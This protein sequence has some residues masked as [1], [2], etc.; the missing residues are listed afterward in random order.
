MVGSHPTGRSGGWGRRPTFPSARGLIRVSEGRV[1]PPGAAQEERPRAW[2]PAG[3][4][5]G[6]SLLLVADDPQMQFVLAA[7]GARYLLGLG[8]LPFAH[9]EAVGDD[10]RAGLEGRFQDGLE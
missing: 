10:A 1:G 4:F 7:V 3:F 9:L 8:R 6:G 5:C 2:R